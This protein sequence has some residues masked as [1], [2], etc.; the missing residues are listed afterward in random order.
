MGE[1]L[2]E[3]LGV[4]ELAIVKEISKDPKTT[5]SQLSQIVEINTTAIENNI[6]KLK[7][8]GILKRI[9]PDKGGYWE[10][11]LEKQRT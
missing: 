3:K 2:G 4:N 7:E 8:K 6:T 9:G 10:V 5:I 1:K 11:N